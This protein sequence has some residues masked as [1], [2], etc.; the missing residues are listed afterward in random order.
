MSARLPVIFRCWPD[1]PDNPI[2]IFPTMREGRGLVNSY[3]R[4][5]QHGA[6][7]WPGIKAD[8]LPASLAQTKQLRRELKAIGY[9]YII[10]RAE[11]G[12]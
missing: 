5:G 1:D 7:S 8:T 6:C 3:Q 2:A 4:I 12:E 9:R 10:A 11:K